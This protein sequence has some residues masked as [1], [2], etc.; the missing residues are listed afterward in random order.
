M[1]KRVLLLAALAGCWSLPGRAA[2][3]EKAAPEKPDKSP[4]ASKAEEVHAEIVR[5]YMDG[6]WEQ[7][8]KELKTATARLSGASTAQK[9]DVAYIR[10]TVAECWPAWWAQCKAGQKGPIQQTVWG[11][12]LQAMFDPAGKGG[13][14]VKQTGREMTM[15]VSW[16]IKTM[17]NP[18][19]AEHSFTKGDLANL[20]VWQTMGSAKVW[21]TLPLQSLVNAT[22]AEKVRLQLYF[23]YW[24]ETTALYYCTPPARHWALWLYLAAFEEKYRKS[25]MTG[26]RRVAAGIL[27]AESLAAPDQYPSLK[28]PTKPPADPVEDALAMHYKNQFVR[29][30]HWTVAEDKRFRA[31]VKSFVTANERQVSSNGRV[32]L[33]NAHAAALHPDDDDPLKPKRAEWFQAQ[34]KKAAGE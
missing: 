23:N 24:G 3:A 10:Q 28:L 29:K 17:D 4:T 9:A 32:R 21:Q 11:Q 30:Q 27:L 25:P 1:F 22:E 13:V 19:H 8:G 12:K 31:A 20:G 2:A 26:S 6:E 7:L 14:E 15:T 33:P 18:D 16:D 5:L 34:L